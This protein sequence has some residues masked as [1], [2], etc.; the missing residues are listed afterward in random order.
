LTVSRGRLVVFDDR[1]AWM[2]VPASSRLMGWRWST[3]DPLDV[4]PLV[5]MYGPDD[6]TAFAGFFVGHHTNF[7][8][9]LTTIILPMWSAVAALAVLPVAFVVL[10]TR[11]CRRMSR[12]DSGRCAACG[13]DLRATPN[14]C[15]EC[16]AVSRG[17]LALCHAT[18]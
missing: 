8:S 4:R 6:H 12:V 14:R 17:C 10:R 5:D 3:A 1:E 11:R 16:G 9:S 2:G 15:P 13:Y 18:E 7:L